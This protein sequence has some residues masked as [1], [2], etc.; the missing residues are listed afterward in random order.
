MVLLGYR[1]RITWVF[2]KLGLII[3][4]YNQASRDVVGKLGQDD[5][6][7]HRAWDTIAVEDE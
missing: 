6:S 1:R 5:G 3:H 4:R 2:L 7:S